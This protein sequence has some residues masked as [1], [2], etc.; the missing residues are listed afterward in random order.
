MIFSHNA[1]QLARDYQPDAFESVRSQ[2]PDEARGIIGQALKPPAKKLA[3]TK[4]AERW[5]ELANCIVQEL[6]KIEKGQDETC[7]NKQS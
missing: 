1:V 4:T 5:F 3:N 7:K 6:F 2:F